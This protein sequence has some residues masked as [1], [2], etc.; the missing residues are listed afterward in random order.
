MCER[1][2]GDGP[3]LEA[4]RKRNRRRRA[5]APQP[6]SIKPSWKK[7]I[8]QAPARRARSISF[9]LSHPRRRSRQS[10]APGITL[11]H[12]LAF[13]VN[14]AFAWTGTGEHARERNRSGSLDR[15]AFPITFSGTM[16]HRR[17]KKDRPGFVGGGQR[18]RREETRVAM[19]PIRSWSGTGTLK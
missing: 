14:F 6:K 1:K 15:I 12:N 5:S 18:A 9:Q 11:I 13:P 17:I 19:G 10:G 7:K 3:G 4:F 16:A 2:S 8:R